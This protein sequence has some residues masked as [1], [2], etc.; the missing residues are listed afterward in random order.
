MATLKYWLWLTGRRGLG[1][2][3]ALRVLDHFVTPERAFYADPE[4]YALV[5][6]LTPAARRALLDKDTGGAERILED[7]ARLDLRIMTLQDADYPERLR[8]LPDPPLALYIRGRAFAFDEEAAVCMVGAREATP[9]G[10]GSAGRL[11]LELARG[12]ALVVSGMAQ[13]IDTASVQYPPGT[14]HRG[15]HFPVRNRI[16]SGLCLG[17]VAVECRPHSGT[18]ITVDRA[19]EQN[20]DLFAVPGN[21][22]APMSQGPNLLI[23]QGAKL[24][25]SGRDILEEYWDRFPAKLSPGE[26]LSP[27]A[28]AARLETAACPAPAPAEREEAPAAP[29]RERIPAAEQRDRFTD[30]ELAL[31]AALGG[32]RRSADELVEAAQIPARRVLSALTMLQV[33]GAVEEGPDRRFSALVELEE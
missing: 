27:A 26:P 14:E 11:G 18:M 33:Q 23:Q 4:E 25:T 20:R 2:A 6:D 21:I 1:N 16:L 28:A 32:R 10:V 29:G 17:V 5:E 19:L 12:G 31:I 8:Q 22:D 30:D 24:V 3:G 7:C 13:G 9:Y 15:E